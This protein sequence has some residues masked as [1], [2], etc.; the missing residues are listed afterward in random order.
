MTTLI[1]DNATPQRRKWTGWRFV[2]IAGTLALL[3]AA[4]N[5]IIGPAIQGAGKRTEAK[6]EQAG[7]D[8]TTAA[9]SLIYR[10]RH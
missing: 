3:A 5:P 2:L 1:G 7:G 8:I 9:N 6:L 10:Q 4:W